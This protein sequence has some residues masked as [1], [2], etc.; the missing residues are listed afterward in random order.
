MSLHVFHMDVPDSAEDDAAR[1]QAAIDAS[2][3]VTVRALAAIG[4]LR[5]L[6][7]RLF[8]LGMEERIAGGFAFTDRHR[9][10]IVRLAWRYREQMPAHLRPPTNPDDPLSPH[11]LVPPGDRPPSHRERLHG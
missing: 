3:A 5:S 7:H 10:H 6:S 9:Q 8:V 2:L 4:R 11:R 1:V